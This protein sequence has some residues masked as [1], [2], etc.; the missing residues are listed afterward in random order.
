MDDN[1]VSETTEK[2]LY[3]LNGADED[4]N[5]EDVKTEVKKVIK[6]RIKVFKQRKVTGSTDEITP[7]TEESV[8]PKSNVS[9]RKKI[10]RRPL[11]K[12]VEETDEETTIPAI[13]DEAEEEIK[14]EI[15]ETTT[16]KRRVIKVSRRVKPT[17]TEAQTIALETTSEQISTSSAATTE[18]NDAANKR[19]VVKVL[20]K[21]FVSKVNDESLESKLSASL[22]KTVTP[23]RQN[24][25]RKYEP[26][27]SVNLNNQNNN[28]L[29]D[30]VTS[31]FTPS[32]L[33]SDDD[34]DDSIN[35]NLNSNRNSNRY[36]NGNDYRNDSGN[37]YRNDN[38]NDSR[39]YN[40]N[41]NNRDEDRN[42]E[43]NND[44]RNEDR[45]NED[46]N[47]EEDDNRNTEDDQNSNE[48]NND[49]QE[50]ELNEPIKEIKPILKFPTRPSNNAYTGLRNRVVTIKRRPSFNDISKT[51]TIH[52]AS[53]SRVFGNANNNTPT[54][55]RQ[56]TIRRK[57][58]PTSS[59][60]SSST[61]VDL[62]QDIDKASLSERNKNI[63]KSYKKGFSKPTL[64]PQNTFTPSQDTDLLTTDYDEVT[65]VTDT[66]NILQKEYQGSRASK[67]NS[68]QQTTTL[69]PT[70]LH[71]IFAIDYEEELK[72]KLSSNITKGVESA[73]DE[74]IKK[75]VKLIEINRVSEVYSKEEKFNVLKNKKLK[76]INSS[77]LILEKASSVDKFSEISRLTLVKLVKKNVSTTTVEPSTAIRNSKNLLF[78]GVETSTIELEG[79]FD[80]EKKSQETEN[81]TPLNNLSLLLR[82]ESNETNTNKAEPPL[83]ISIANLD[84]V[85]LTKTQKDLELLGSTPLQSVQNVV[86][87][88]DIPTTTED[89]KTET[90][91]E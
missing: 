63:F 11:K 91:I 52:P 81:T 68:N 26:N 83:V 36:N 15:V 4:E 38:G 1:F 61:T 86:S 28:N 47:N 55:A 46:R 70:T 87:N 84:Q 79:L 80:R 51:T 25:I 34:D 65:D 30:K 20:R 5:S 78:P 7:T 50:E 58:K 62:L 89:D 39:L 31:R 16:K 32:L 19:K 41:N 35:D 59:S 23:S 37:D 90:P 85:I 8:K 60:G 40:K 82:P 76:S 66:N 56:V 73:A 18:R 45:N 12:V 48:N 27:A 10:I 75:L 57:Y 42:N 9:R 43:R 64:S 54:K 33:E 3:T 77:D 24:F 69:K 13:T 71:H 44:N 88:V 14:Q 67:N 17:T 72:K 22:S 53:T 6:K 49:N 29:D 74:V 2:L 21:P